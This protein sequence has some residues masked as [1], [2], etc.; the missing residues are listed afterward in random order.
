[1][2]YQ[3]KAFH[4]TVE[5]DFSSVRY[6][7]SD[8]KGKVVTSRTLNV[9]HLPYL[10]YISLLYSGKARCMEKLFTYAH[11]EADKELANIKKYTE[12]V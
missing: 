1:M 6:V 2:T 10:T 12:G 8:E 4:K 7:I 11:Q 9:Y 3:K 5:Q